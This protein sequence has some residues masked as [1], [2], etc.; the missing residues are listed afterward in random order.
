MDLNQKVYVITKGIYSD[1]VRAKD[2]Q[3]AMKIAQDEYAK[4]KAEKEG[5]V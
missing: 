4:W 2:E 3:R 1:Y 5:V